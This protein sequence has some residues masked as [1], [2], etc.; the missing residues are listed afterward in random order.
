[1][2]KLQRLRIEY[3]KELDVFMEA[4]EN[5]IRN[6]KLKRMCCPCKVCRNLRM[7]DDLRVIRQHLDLEGIMH[8]EG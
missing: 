1:M 2:Y 7:W 8:G 5:Y 6:N 3:E 4:V